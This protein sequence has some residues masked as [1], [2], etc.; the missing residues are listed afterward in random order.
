VVLISQELMVGENWACR[1][2]AEINRKEQKLT[3]LIMCELLIF[4]NG[5][6]AWPLSS[7]RT[8]IC[9]VVTA[10]HGFFCEEDYR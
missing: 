10:I 5:R 7:F 4:F 1:P 8:V 9:P 6:L 2:R 3:F